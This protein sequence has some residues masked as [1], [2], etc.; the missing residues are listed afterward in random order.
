MKEKMKKYGRGF[1]YVAAF[2]AAVREFLEGA[3]A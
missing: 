1:V 3:R 2:V